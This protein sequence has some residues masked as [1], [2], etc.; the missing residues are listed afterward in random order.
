MFS[1]K[2]VKKPSNEQNSLEIDPS[3]SIKS[4]H[5]ANWFIKSVHCPILNAQESESLAEILDF[6]PPE[7]LFCNNY[8]LLTYNDTRS[9]S[10]NNNIFEIRL[11]PVDALKLVK[12][13]PGSE[14]HIKVKNSSSWSRSR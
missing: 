11:C 9:Q 13:G 3:T 1:F 7:M 5:H 14:A 12:T 10:S 6:S 4:F 8:L 2:V